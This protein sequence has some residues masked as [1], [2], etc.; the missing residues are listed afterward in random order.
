MGVAHL[1]IELSMDLL[2]RQAPPPGGLCAML[3]TGFPATY[4]DM[5]GIAPASDIL[6]ILN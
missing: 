4:V 5:A 3:V 1:R 6:L 2:M